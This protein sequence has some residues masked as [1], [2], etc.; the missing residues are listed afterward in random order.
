MSSKLI[1]VISSGDPHVRDLPLEGYCRDASFGQL[2][3]DCDELDRF[4]RGCDNLYQRVRALF[5]LYAIHRY[6]LPVKLPPGSAGFVPFDGYNHLL[7][8][9]FEE[10]IEVFLVGAAGGTAPVM[11]SPAP[12]RRRI[13]IWAFRRW[14]TRCGAAFGRCAATSGCSASG[15]RRISRCAS[16]RNCCGGRR[17][18]GCFPSSRRRRR[19]AWTCRTAPG[20]T[21]SSSGWISPKGHG[22]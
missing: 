13:T 8:R 21:F 20:A 11:P 19:C 17:R 10:A 12:W 18:I 9:R 16:G 14:P 3:A 22:C 5:F 7:A 2:L 15:I 1:D 6:H 4:R